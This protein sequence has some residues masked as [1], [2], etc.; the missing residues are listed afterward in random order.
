[1]VLVV[2]LMYVHVVGLV[3]VLVVVLVEILIV[4]VLVVVLE[5]VLLYV[6]DNISRYGGIFNE[7]IGA[8]YE[9]ERERESF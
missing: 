9:R 7:T 5:V 4:E 6:D 1:M 3:M 2:V 8:N